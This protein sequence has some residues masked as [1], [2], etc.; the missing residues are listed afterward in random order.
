M[1]PPSFRQLLVA[2]TVLCFCLFLYGR[3][4]WSTHTTGV[5]D[6]WAKPPPPPPQPQPPSSPPEQQDQASSG[7]EHQTPLQQV[8][9]HWN[10]Y[11][12]LDAF[13]HGIRTLVDY[14]SWIPEQSK[15]SGD[16]RI[17]DKV[18]FDPVPANPYTQLEDV[19]TCYLDAHD[20]VPAPDVFSYPGIPAY[21]P[22]PYFGAYE[23]LGMAPD[24]C[25]ER[26]GRLG[27]YG[28]SYPK[29]KGGFG[30]ETPPADEPVL[31]RMIKKYDYTDIN[32]DTV[33]KRC[34]EKNRDRFV[35][36]KDAAKAAGGLGR[37]WP[38]SGKDTKKPLARNVLILRA[39]TGIEWTPM[40]IINTRALITELSL[41]SGGQF[42]VHI[43]M[44]IVDD[45]IDISNEATAKKMVRDNV[46]EEF[47]DIT[48][49]WSVPDMAARYPGFRDD[50]TLENDSH[51]PIYSV[52]RI[53]HFALQWF[54]QRHPEYE[55]FWNWEL[56]LRFTGHYYEFFDSA[57]RWA[58]KQPR[59]YLWE[60]NERFWIPGLHG[61]WQ[62]FVDLV[63]KE[64]IASREASPWGPLLNEGIVDTAT[65]PPTTIER[66]NYEWGVGEAADLVS[67]SPLFDPAKNAWSLRYDI[68]GYNDT[69]PPRRTSIITI[70][71]FSRRLLQAM[72][73][74]VSRNKHT[75]FPEMFPG[76]IALHHG[77]KAVYIPHPIYFDRR[78][79]LDRLDSVFNHAETPELSV[80]YWPFTPGTSEHNF[81]TSTYYYNTEFGPQLWHRW[82]GQEDAG[83]G[84]P[85]LEQDTGR[86]CLRGVL[87]HPVKFDFTSDKAIGAT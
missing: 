26:F 27:P 19:Q 77:L 24:Q 7:G 71:R 13:Y 78:W 51:K 23:N 45:S 36:G 86:M 29:S 82:L 25:W 64:T 38:Q 1:H 10:D 68:T 60:R 22:A 75:M 85:E 50:M 5:H 59:K 2:S 72:H 46:P 58:D 40:R 81:L 6:E 9:W 52:Y 79:P 48:T 53:P 31:D 76:S 35:T 34:L 67:F 83:L 39:W 62:D 54:A 37:L 69:V 30:L 21:M 4:L 12:S 65:Y 32:W 80:Y 63:E 33:Q 73:E 16:V 87:M 84:G 41:K 57:A 44:H 17:L 55:Y 18:P 70:G 61:R 47:W 28:Y 8:P 15:D 43:L 11:T 42:D 20:T 14:S 3:R 66:D 56:D 49:P 74:E